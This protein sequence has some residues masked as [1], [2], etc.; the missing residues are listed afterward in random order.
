MTRIC[1]SD[2][3]LSGQ[4]LSAG[5]YSQPEIFEQEG[6][7]Y[8]LPHSG[9]ELIYKGVVYNEMKGSYSSPV[10]VLIDR[11]KKSLYPGTIYRHSSGGDPQHI[12]ALTMSSFW[13]RTGIIITRRTV[14]SIS[15]VT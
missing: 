10:T 6:W 15:M 11:I 1:Q 2:G 12:P 4:R 9:D 13:R 8:E 3:G 7:H 5:I 14:I